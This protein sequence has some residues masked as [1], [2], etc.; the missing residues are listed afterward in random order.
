MG[1]RARQAADDLYDAACRQDPDLLLPQAYSEALDALI[2]VGAD[3][4]MVLDLIQSHFGH[5]NWSFLK[6]SLQALKRLG[7]PKASNLLSRIVVFA[8]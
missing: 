2:S 4:E 6:D 8:F 1:T 7:T 3:E 5:T